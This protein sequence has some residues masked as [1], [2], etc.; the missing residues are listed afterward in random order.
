MRIAC[1]TLCV[2][3]RENLQ[4]WLLLG[5]SKHPLLL[6]LGRLAP[7]HKTEVRSFL[8]PRPFEPDSNF[9]ST[10]LNGGCAVGVGAVRAWQAVTWTRRRWLVKQG[11]RAFLWRRL[12]D[13]TRR[14]LRRCG[15]VRVSTKTRALVFLFVC[16][17]VKLFCLCL[18]CCY[19]Y[20]NIQWEMY[21]CVYAQFKNAQNY[22]WNMKINWIYIIVESLCF[23]QKK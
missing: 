8:L 1:L 16:K 23:W 12:P 3:H 17:T 22:I 4:R 7:A 6:P 21:C 19:V 13:E 5:I 14:S 18:R 9:T 20:F 11:T 10:R 2:S 15:C